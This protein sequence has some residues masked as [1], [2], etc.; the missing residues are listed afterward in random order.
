[1][2]VASESGV[3]ELDI[4]AWDLWVPG[5]DLAMVVAVLSF[6]GRRRVGYWAVLVGGPVAPFVVVADLDVPPPAGGLE[7]RTTGLWADA[8]LEER[9]RR[10]SAGLEAFAVGVDD[11][12][13]YRGVDPAV[14]RGERVPLGFDLEWEAADDPVAPGPDRP[15]CEVRGE[16]LVGSDAIELQDLG[17]VGTFAGPIRRTTADGAGWWGMVGGQATEG[18]GIAPE[19]ADVTALIPLQ[20]ADGLHL[21]RRRWSLGAAGQGWSEALVVSSPRG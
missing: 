21:E 9:G 5:G 13:A 11:A 7:L 18:G 12:A 3:G 14:V 6:P 4:T 2:D 16:L 20:I 8:N 10:W 17:A 15:S 1:M 19:G